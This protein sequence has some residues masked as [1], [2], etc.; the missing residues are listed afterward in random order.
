MRLVTFEYDGAVRLGAILD[1][2]D[3][4]DLA[5]AA[6]WAGTTDPAFATMLSL[7]DEG[8][9]AL[10]RARALAASPPGE[11]VLG[12]AAIR[13]LAPLPR[14]TQIRD[15]SAFEQHMLQ[16]GKV[17]FTLNAIR[18]G[19]EPPKGPI[20]LPKVWY[21]QPIYYKANRFAVGN[22]GDDVPWPPY[23]QL[24]DYE[25]EM[26]AVIGRKG[27]DIPASDAKSH[28]FG[29]TIYNDF[30]A[31]DAQG[32]EMTGPFGPAKGKDFDGSIIL[33]PC[34]VTADEMP[35]PYQARMTA[36]VNGEVWSEGSMSTIHWRFED[37]I[38]H[39]SAGET[40]YPGEIFGA[41]TVGGGC[42]LEQERF[43]TDG[44]VIE[45]RIEGIGAIRNRVIGSQL[46]R[47]SPA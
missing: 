38:A 2:G 33:G 32:H 45:L 4:L 34:I 24:A 8:E 39:V 10:D 23:S 44:D 18:A 5:A 43:L 42:G 31:R 7:I 21:D 9:G 46:R 35:D 13:L 28:I 11:A 27:R 6:A 22:P 30:S 41:G 19:K 1:D 26:A 47:G 20:V 36:T 40:I 3:I 37:M 12:A 16:S 15:F 17:V 29:Y 25:L 14:P